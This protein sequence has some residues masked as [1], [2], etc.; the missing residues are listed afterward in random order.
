MFF[1]QVEFSL[2]SYCY[3]RMCACVFDISTVPPTC[4]AIVL[5]GSHCLVSSSEVFPE[6]Y[7]SR[8]LSHAVR[9]S[10]SLTEILV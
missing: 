3:I 8:N 1:F 5:W 6:G 10:L 4:F 9:Y 7:D 2:L